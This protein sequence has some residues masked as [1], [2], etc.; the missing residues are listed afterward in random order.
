MADVT[1]EGLDELL[2]KLELIP[3][4]AESAFD[5]ALNEAADNLI[6]EMK[7]TNSF[8]DASGDLRKSIAKSNVKGTG[9]DKFI[10][11]GP[12]KTTAWRAHFLEFGTSKMTAKPFIEPAHLKTR[13]QNKELIKKRIKEALGI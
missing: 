13:A 8:Q 7:Q 1:V 3:Q 9:T 11:I 12:D 10:E 5:E 6:K 2:S 4:K